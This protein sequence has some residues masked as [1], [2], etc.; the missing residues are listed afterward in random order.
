QAL[1]T[2]AQH[3]A[4]VR[5]MDGINQRQQKLD[6]LNFRL[7]K[8]ER[9]VIEQHR[10]RWERASAAV[11]HYDA[12]RV[13]AGIRKDLASHTANLGAAVRNRLIVQKSRLERLQLQLQAL[14]PVAI[15][16]RGYALV[17]DSA[18]KLVK[19]TD[20]VEV[21]DRISARLAQGRLTAKVE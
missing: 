5:M 6:D 14:S 19:S 7:E 10:R 12:R 2:A 15:L 16:E 11:R 13:V 1:T 3:G 20:Q 21:G 18:G 17:F 4:F 8:A 9:R